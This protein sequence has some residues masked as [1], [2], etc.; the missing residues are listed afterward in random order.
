[1]SGSVISITN[2][3][4]IT[5]LLFTVAAGSVDAIVYLAAHVFTANMTGNAVLFGIDAGQGHALA[6]TH[7][8]VAL[9]AFIIGIVAGAMIVRQYGKSTKWTFV[10]NAVL[11]EAV[12]LALFAGA[13]LLP[14][15]SPLHQPSQSVAPALTSS[16]QTAV[17]V[18]QSQITNH[19]SPIRSES[20]AANH[21]SQTPTAIVL[22]IVFSGLAMGLQSAVVRGLNLP[23]IATTYITGTI[24]NLFSG[25]VHHWGH[26][27]ET[28]ADRQQMRD[29]RS[30]L[31]LQAE[32]FAAYALAAV[33]CGALYSRWPA[34]VALLPVLAIGAVTIYMFVRHRQLEAAGQHGH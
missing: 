15:S 12:L 13:F 18:Q 14:S 23:G 21:P 25:L 1:M 28:E 9:L 4:R 34:A 16:I 26:P 2:R 27:T 29:L 8:I 22:I 6:A 3:R 24:T 31:R 30:N 17:A 20:P 32:V 7:S 11:L 10:R 5:I 33:A 19:Q